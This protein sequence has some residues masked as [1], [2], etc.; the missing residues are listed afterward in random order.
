MGYWLTALSMLTF[1]ENP[2]GAR[3]GSAAAAG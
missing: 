3:F 1:G 2:F